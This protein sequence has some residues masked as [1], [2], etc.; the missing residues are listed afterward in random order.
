M[1][2]NITIVNMWIC[3]YKMSVATVIELRLISYFVI[4]SD[5]KKKQRVECMLCCKF[6][7][8]CYDNLSH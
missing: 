3:Y 6:I 2:E 4:L 8:E 7:L 1:K 5:T